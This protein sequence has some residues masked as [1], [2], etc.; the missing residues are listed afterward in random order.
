MNVV[1]QVGDK[2]FNNVF[3]ALIESNLTSK[4]PELQISSLFDDFNWSI[5]PPESIEFLEDRVVDKIVALGRP[6]R[7]FYSGGT[8]STSV[9]RAFARKKVP[10]KY[11]IC[12]NRTMK[13][14]ILDSSYW[15][16]HHIQSLK[17]ILDQNGLGEPEVEQFEVDSRI[18]NEHYGRSYFFEKGS[19]YGTTRGF[20]MGDN[21]AV[22]DFSKFDASQHTNVFGIEKPR[23]YGQDRLYWQ[24]T[25][26]MSM[27]G[28][29]H[30][31]PCYW[32]YL[33][34]DVPELISKQCWNVINYCKIKWPQL[35]LHVSTKILQTNKNYY[36]DWCLALGR[37]ATPWLALMCHNTKPIGE[38]F[39]YLSDP[40][41]K[42]LEHF[43]DL[44]PIAWKNFKGLFE[45]LYKL[46]GKKDISS[47]T[48]K[49]FY[50]T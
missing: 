40:R 45:E 41:Y 6:I 10:I 20:N 8:D 29:N 39:T 42:H 28:Y 35:P 30:N 15:V 9:A 11:T 12:V 32:F 38:Q 18:L 5:E 36:Y 13:D 23:V 26:T 7:M 47:I 43:K 31:Y 1:Y 49:R 37:Y 34:D 17:N 46:T 3:K 4:E 22:L 21:N 27:H 14:N 19:F 44:N 50:L 2:Q 25:D 16:E 33:N 48:T 24:I